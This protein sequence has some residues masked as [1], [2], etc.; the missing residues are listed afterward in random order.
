MHCGKLERTVLYPPVNPRDKLWSWLLRMIVCKESNRKCTQCFCITECRFL[1][2][3]PAIYCAP[4]SLF[5]GL[6]FP[7][8]MIFIHRANLQQRS[9]IGPTRSLD[10]ENGCRSPNTRNEK[11]NEYVHSIRWRTWVLAMR[12]LRPG[13]LLVND[14]DIDLAGLGPIVTNE[15]WIL[16]LSCLTGYALGPWKKQTWK[17]ARGLLC[18]NF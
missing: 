14:V 11:N 8:S 9:K 2:H 3:A 1:Y 17:K 6:R 5:Y 10:G 4:S 18:S 16:K 15:T 7:V 13:K 12:D